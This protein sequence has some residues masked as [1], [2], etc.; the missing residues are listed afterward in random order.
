MTYLEDIVVGTERSFGQYEVTEGEIIAFGKLYDDQPFHTDPEAAKDSIYGGLIAS[1]WHT[2]AMFMR[3][4]VD[5][6]DKD[7]S[8]AGLGSPGFDDLK[9]LL[10]V[11][12]GDTLSAQTKI[13]SATPSRSKL[14]RGTVRIQ[15]TIFNQTGALVLEMTSMGRYLRRPTTS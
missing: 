13:L 7:N 14:D 15:I 5:A 4:A 1:G 6:Q 10:P 2:C 9:W 8:L 11:R 3:M 12:P